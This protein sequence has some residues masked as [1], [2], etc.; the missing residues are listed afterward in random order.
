MSTL[1]FLSLQ[2]SVHVQFRRKFRVLY[3]SQF[4]WV[5]PNSS[6]ANI[7]SDFENLEYFLY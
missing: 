3:F 4:N 1:Q 2:V 7:Y 5:N 6:E